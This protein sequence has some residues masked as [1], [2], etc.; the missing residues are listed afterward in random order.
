MIKVVDG[1]IRHQGKSYSNGMTVTGLSKQEEARLVSLGVAEQIKEENHKE[2]EPSE[3][4]ETLDNAEPPKDP[5][6]ISIEFNEEEYI[7]AGTTEKPD[8]KGGE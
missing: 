5:E 3:D 7:N 8:K 6:G 1:I 2:P 4:S